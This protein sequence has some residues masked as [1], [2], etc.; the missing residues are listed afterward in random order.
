MHYP[1][2]DTDH[3][4]PQN[5]EKLPGYCAGIARVSQ[6]VMPV[7]VHSFQLVIA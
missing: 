6:A 2:A 3:F 5:Q 7:E 1:E 4:C